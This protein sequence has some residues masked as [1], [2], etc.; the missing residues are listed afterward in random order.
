[1]DRRSVVLSF[2]QAPVQSVGT[3]SSV[4][5]ADLMRGSFAI[6]QGFFSA[7]SL[8]EKVVPPSR[9]NFSN[10]GNQS[11]NNTDIN[12]NNMGTIRITLNNSS[13][14]GSTSPRQQNIFE[15]NAELV[16]IA[17]DQY[18]NERTMDRIFTLLPYLKRFFGMSAHF[19]N[20]NKRQSS[21]FFGSLVY[22]GLEILCYFLFPWK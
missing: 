10:V 3:S 22:Y 16:K 2:Q 15:I 1:M 8:W 21:G 13:E 6:F 9:S 18:I 12:S 17:L 5:V 20:I 19:Y 11:N 7:I 4:I 14:I